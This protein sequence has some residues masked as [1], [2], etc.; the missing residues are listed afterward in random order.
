[1]DIFNLKRDRDAWSTIRGYVYQVDL[2]LENWIL[3]EDNEYLELERAEDIDVVG[4]LNDNSDRVMNQIKHREKNLTLRSPEAIEALINFHDH[5]RVNSELQLFF[6]FITN[7]EFTIERPS[8]FQDRIS[9]IAVWE[10]LRMNGITDQSSQEQLQK[11]KDFLLACTRPESIE[12]KSWSNWMMFLQH[13]DEQDFYDFIKRFTWSTSNT[14]F[15]QM[16]DKIKEL[17]ISRNIALSDHEANKVYERLFLHVFKLLSASGIKRLNKIDFAVLAQRALYSEDEELLSK[18]QR[19]WVEIETRVDHIERTLETQQAQVK[20]LDKH[21]VAL[22]EE[23]GF[24]ASLRFNSTKPLID[25][26]QFDRVIQREIIVRQLLENLNTLTMISLHGDLGSGKTQLA[27]LIAH[28]HSVCKGWIRLRDLSPIYASIRIDEALSSISGI[29]PTEHWQDWYAQVCARI[30]NKSLI[31]LD[32]LPK[33]NGK[34]I[35]D[36]KL[37]MLVRACKDANVKL[38]TTSALPLPPAFQTFLLDRVIFSTEAP[39]FDEND[40]LELMTQFGAT[41]DVLENSKF[42]TLVTSLTKG[43]PVLATAAVHY[44]QEHTWQI[45]IEAFGA[46]FNGQYANNL[47]TFIQQELLNQLEDSE[48]REFLYRLTLIQASFDNKQIQM[49]SRVNPVIARPFERLNDVL[50]LWLQKDFELNYQVT[51]LLAQ[52]GPMNLNLT[53]IKEVRFLL[54]QDIIRKRDIHP[55][56][57]IRALGYFVGAEAYN[58]AGLVLLLSLEQVEKHEAWNDIWGFT[59]IWIET[60]L[61]ET[62]ELKMKLAIRMKQI[63]IFNRMD[64]PTNE[65]LEKIELLLLA[66]DPQESFIYDVSL[67]VASQLALISP[68]KANAHILRALK[69]SQLSTNNQEEFDLIHPGTIIWMTAAGVQ[70]AL[71]LDDWLNTLHKFSEF[72]LQYATQSDLY[73]ESSITFC[74]SLWLREASKPKEQQ[75]WHEILI[76]LEKIREC[77]KKLK[78]KILWACSVRS[79]IIVLG[80]YQDQIVR[81][82]QL[83][84]SSLNTSFDSTADSM[85]SIDTIVEFL[86]RGAMGSQYVY[87]EQFTDA[88][89]WLSNAIKSSTDSYPYQKIHSYLELSKAYGLLNPALSTYF[90]GKAV[91]ISQLNDSIPSILRVKSIGEHLIASLAEGSI[92]N[93]IP[94]YE[95]AVEY[96]LQADFSIDDWKSLFVIFGHASGYFLS[97]VSNG[98]PPKSLNDEERYTIPE[99]GFFLIHRPL[100][101]AFY[102]S[103]NDFFLPAHLAQLY[104]FYGYPDKAAEWTLRTFDIARERGARRN[105]GLLGAQALPILLQKQEYA[106]ALDIAYEMYI[107]HSMRSQGENYLGDSYTILGAKPS[108]SWDRI[109]ES[110]AEYSVFLAAIQLLQVQTAD[111]KQTAVLAMELISLCKQFKNNAS[112]P[113]LWNNLIINIDTLFI[114]ILSYKEYAQRGNSS[115]KW[116]CIRCLYYLAASFHAPSSK[117]ILKIYRAIFHFISSFENWEELN[118]KVVIP[119]VTFHWLSILGNFRN[120]FSFPENVYTALK[121]YNEADSEVNLSKLLDAIHTS[122]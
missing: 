99:R 118:K 75:D 49:I 61:P 4:M 9:G 20:N 96:L 67:F 89:T 51:P 32:D 90:S 23:V 76:S 56:E 112:S 28:Q 7:A 110:A 15:A 21:F 57:A 94:L 17:L 119:F 91:E 18:I 52:I 34:T 98:E 43:H 113:D 72:Q 35:L 12:Q 117:D 85:D 78:L 48:T 45:N 5:R 1:M 83:A 64:K 122:F 25:I 82:E 93:E 22:K 120:E 3:L 13:V 33:T 27:S 2:S 92:K 55:F 58:E 74:D 44:L 31:V 86:I 79:A 100:T 14:P 68:I 63:S 104:E 108:E 103:E 77:T 80:E 37:I 16:E 105:I 38:L 95:E 88:I 65:L 116:A 50:G 84:L 30:G 54:G 106:I 115:N 111:P 11:I 107:I 81:A 66:A 47:N 114:N 6:R 40:L 26:P 70:N 97:M 36:E 59:L 73:L 46:L 42:V 109:E 8:I 71:Q 53:T 87:K 10:K 101:A 121:F 41:K 39:K 62:M 69:I 29:T 24:N 19:I 60:P 102:Q